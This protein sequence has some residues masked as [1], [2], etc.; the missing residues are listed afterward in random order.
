MADNNRIIREDFLEKLVNVYAPTGSE[1]PAQRV[2]K[3]YLKDIV[4]K[5]ETDVMGNVSAILN[6][7]GNPKI[8]LAGHCDEVGF[9]IRYIDE[10]GFIYVSSLGG[11]DSHIVPG[12]RVKILTNQGEIWGVIGRKAIHL[13]KP[14]ER[15]KVTPLKDQYVD[16]GVSSKEEVEKLGI[17][18]GDPIVF[19]QS[20]MK[21]GDQ[22][23]VA[24]RCF[25]DRIAVFIIAEIMRILKNEQISAAVYGVSTVQEEIGTRGAITSTYGINPDVGIALDVTHASD[26]PD[27]QEK[28]VGAVKLGGGPVIVRGP[29]VNPK[30]FELFVETAEQEKIPYQIRAASRPTGTDARSI[31]MTRGGVATGLIGIPN[32]YMH[33]MSETVHLD[34]VDAI[35]RLLVATIKKITKETSFIPE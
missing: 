12:H 9:Q 16:I 24:S 22:G 14:D 5:T 6:A 21:L 2:Y 18:I 30:L 19:T 29:N 3:D 27:V 4:E 32:R 28:E 35:V 31:Q 33:T 10:K 23:V 8:M 1:E 34:D 20:Y 26:S 17:R 7:D 11:V 25:D 13:V 15:K